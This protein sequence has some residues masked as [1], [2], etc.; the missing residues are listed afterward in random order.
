M[1]TPLAAAEKSGPGPVCHHL[2]LSVSLLSVQR[3]NTDLALSVQSGK[4]Y[5]HGSWP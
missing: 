1:S 5:R 4:R 2:S 3:Y